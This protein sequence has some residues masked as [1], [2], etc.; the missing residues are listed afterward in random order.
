[1]KGKVIIRVGDVP[2]FSLASSIPL[3]EK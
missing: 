3:E 1:M 2:H